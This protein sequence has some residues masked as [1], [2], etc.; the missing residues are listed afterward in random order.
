MASSVPPLS[1][2][3][4]VRITAETLI[5]R[6]QRL[7]ALEIQSARL[8]GGWL[9]G[10]ARW[11]VKHEIG[12]HLW[13]DAAHS[14]DLRTRL[15][16]LRVPNPDRGLGDDLPRLVRAFAGAEEDYEFLAGLYFILKAQLVAAYEA[17]VQDTDAVYDAPTIAFIRRLLPEKQA[18]LAGTPHRGRRRLG[19]SGAV[20]H[21]GR[22]P[23]RAARPKMGAAADA[24]FRL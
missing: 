15:W 22:N 2:R 16:E 14:K 20:R 10:V 3:A 7:Q 12:L 24:S 19:R 5:A 11:E 23:A 21:H 8:L 6:L 17:I 9:P 1:A 18:Q 13:Q 4:S